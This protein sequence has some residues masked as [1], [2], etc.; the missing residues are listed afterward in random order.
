MNI[1]YHKW[2]SPH[3]DRDMELKVYEMR[4][5]LLSFFPTQA[6]RFFQAEDEGIMESVFGFINDGRIHMIA[7]DSIDHESCRTGKPHPHQK[8]I[9]S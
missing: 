3:L 9:T 4:E 5:N 6:G 1:G 8:R 7:V 2:H